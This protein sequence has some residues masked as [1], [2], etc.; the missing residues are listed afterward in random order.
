MPFYEDPMPD[1]TKI[2]VTFT[3]KGDAARATY[4]YMDVKDTVRV[5]AAKEI[6]LAGLKSLGLVHPKYSISDMRNGY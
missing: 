3:L 1:T 6:Y 4:K 2:T 5:T